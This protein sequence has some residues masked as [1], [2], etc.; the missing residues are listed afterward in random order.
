LLEV[1]WEKK[2]G[3]VTAKELIRVIRD[4][5]ESEKKQDHSVVS[6]DALLNYLSALE[7]HADNAV[8][9]EKRKFESDLAVFRAE[10]ER[11]LAHYEAQQAHSVEMLKAVITYGHFTLNSAMLINGGAA[12]ALLAFIG[13]IWAKEI[14]HGAVGA[15]TSSI[16]YFS[17]G[18]LA[19]AVAAAGSYFTQYFY[20]EKFN[21]TGIVFHT[22]TVVLAVAAYVLF[23]FG[24]YDAYTA[25]VHHLTSPSK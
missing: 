5:V 17:F 11:N 8:E 20:S 3:L 2:G 16:R 13:N 19:A 25:F 12:A 15:L 24:A 6:T 4:A 23:G 1:V 21:R 18:V 7:A 9:G 14:A 22:L 10:H